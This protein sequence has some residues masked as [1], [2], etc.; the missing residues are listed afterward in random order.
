MKR[1]AL[2]GA[3]LGALV[4]G[5]G[6]AAATQSFS[7]GIYRSPTSTCSAGATNTAGAKYGTFTVTETNGFQSVDASVTVDNLYADR[8]YNVSVNEWGQSCLAIHLA[9][10]FTTDSHGKAVVHFQFWAHTGETSAWVQIRHGATGD[11]LRS[12]TVP[13][14]R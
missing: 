11:I 1:I 10:S 9:A 14:N 12:T 8:A 5:I 4:F 6:N 3:L 7:A 2:C 13:I